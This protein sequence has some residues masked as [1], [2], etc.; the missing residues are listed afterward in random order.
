[1]WLGKFSMCIYISA[2]SYTDRLTAAHTFG[3]PKAKWQLLSEGVRQS[4]AAVA[5]CYSRTLCFP[6]AGGG[7][8]LRAV[9]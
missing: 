9:V 4:A 2:K 5:V 8:W 3:R 6:K 1:M 7:A